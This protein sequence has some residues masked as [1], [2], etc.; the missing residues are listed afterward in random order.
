M[1]NDLKKKE[2][3][4]RKWK[5]VKALLFNIKIMKRMKINIEDLMQMFSNKP[6]GPYHS[7]TFFDAVKLGD[8]DEVEKLIKADRSLVF[9]S[10]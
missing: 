2:F 10:D 1:E 6:L 4:K 9:A 7:S 8:F 5:F 3:S